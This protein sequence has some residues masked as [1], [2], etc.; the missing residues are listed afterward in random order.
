MSNKAKTA[1]GFTKKSH[2]VVKLVYYRGNK[3][4]KADKSR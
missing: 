3:T 1:D 4:R 2:N